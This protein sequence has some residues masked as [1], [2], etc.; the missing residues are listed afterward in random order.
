M[1]ITLIA[2][3]NDEEDALNGLSE[4]VDTNFGE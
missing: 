4:L 1:T 2:D 3:G